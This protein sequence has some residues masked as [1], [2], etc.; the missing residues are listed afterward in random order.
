MAFSW[1]FLFLVVFWV[2]YLTLIGPQILFVEFYKNINL[3]L[4]LLIY[5]FLIIEFKNAPVLFCEFWLSLFFQKLIQLKSWNYHFFFFF[6]LLSSRYIY[7]NYAG[8]DYLEKFFYVQLKV[9]SYA[10]HIC[11][12]F[13]FLFCKLEVFFVSLKKQN[14]LKVLEKVYNYNYYE[15]NFL[16]YFFQNTNVV[17]IF[18]IINIWLFIYYLT[19]LLTNKVFI[20]FKLK[21]NNLM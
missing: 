3:F 15:I 5:L 7:I 16:N 14:S 17:Y 13:D 11:A 19:L 9:N 6:F 21:K 12:N 4:I 2:F 8:I 20:F 1:S 10:N 18:N